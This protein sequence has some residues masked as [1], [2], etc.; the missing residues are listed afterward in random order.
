LQGTKHRHHL[1]KGTSKRDPEA[2]KDKP[3]VKKQHVRK[4]S[5]SSAGRAAPPAR[6]D[7]GA[8]MSKKDSK[9]DSR[10][11]KGK[12]DGEYDCDSGESDKDESISNESN[13]SEFSEDMSES[14][15]S[16]NSRD[17]KANIKF[18][19]GSEELEPITPSP[20]PKRM[21]SYMSS[22]PRVRAFADLLSSI[23]AHKMADFV[24]VLTRGASVYGEMQMSVEQIDS[25][26]WSELE[27]MV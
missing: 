17:T 22:P 5:I 18:K 19:R 7:S 12:R 20:S 11:S 23:P 4:E 24:A 2:K 15:S 9:K 16:S 25:G 26:M 10:K 27:M 21:R 8:V 14:K 6:K 1:I 13:D 3:T